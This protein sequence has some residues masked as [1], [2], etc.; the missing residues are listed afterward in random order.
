VC[1]SI[2]FNLIVKEYLQDTTST[3][4]KLDNLKIRRENLKGAEFADRVEE[5]GKQKYH[6]LGEMLM[7]G[8]IC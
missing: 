2:V 4:G 5:S 3:H 8:K 6:P 7:I 1:T